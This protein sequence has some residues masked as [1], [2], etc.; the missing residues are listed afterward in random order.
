MWECRCT[1]RCM[2]MCVGRRVILTCMWRAESN[3]WE[4]VS[5]LPHVGHQVWQHASLPAEP[6]WWFWKPS[7]KAL[8]LS[9][10]WI[11]W[12]RVLFGGTRSRQEKFYHRKDET[13]PPGGWSYLRP[14][15]TTFT[16]MFSMGIITGSC[17]PSQQRP[18]LPFT[19]PMTLLLW[20]SVH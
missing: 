9:C 18:F 13:K 1:Y 10:P 15:M 4:S 14:N 2:S 5:F 8:N 7:S 6:L 12:G 19:A 20:S 11:F 3:L 16:A 17:D